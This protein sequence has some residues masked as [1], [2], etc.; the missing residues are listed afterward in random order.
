MGGWYKK[1]LSFFPATLNAGCKNN[2]KGTILPPFWKFKLVQVTRT[3]WNEEPQWQVLF[4]GIEP[5]WTKNFENFAEN[6][7]KVFNRTGELE[8]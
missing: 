2:I 7:L 4:W 8:R 6:L 5:K 3:I 1:L